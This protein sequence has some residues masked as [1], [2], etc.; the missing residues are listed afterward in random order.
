MP[1]NFILKTTFGI[2][3]EIDA[4]KYFG[5]QV[6]CPSL[7]T[8]SKQTRTLSAHVF[9]VRGTNSQL[10]PSTGRTDIDEKVLW[11]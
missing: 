7:L 11:S 2:E 1:G 5:G 3:G 6:K 9:I 8:D 4:R 10:N